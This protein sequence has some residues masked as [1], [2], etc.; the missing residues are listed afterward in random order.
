MS[1]RLLARPLSA[2]E[3][4]I[5]RRA[6]DDFKD[7]YEHSPEDVEKLLH[8]GERVPDPALP[9]AEYAAFTMLANQLLNLDEVLNK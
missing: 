4:L 3:R 8:T 7:Y 1:I 9:S 2:P 5:A 6:F